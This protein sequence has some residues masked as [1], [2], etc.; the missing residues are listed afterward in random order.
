M[1]AHRV[2]IGVAALAV[3]SAGAAR[4]DLRLHRVDLIEH[5]R[6]C[7]FGFNV[8][9]SVR[10]LVSALD[11]EGRVIDLRGEDFTLILDS[12]E[13]Q[14][15]FRLTRF[16]S[17][18]PPEEM[19]VVVVIQTSPSM[20]GALDEAARGVGA[21]ADSL[22]AKPTWKMALLDY[23]RDVRTRAQLSAAAT[24]K[25]VL[26]R[27][28]VDRE[29]GEVHLLDAVRTAIDQLKAEPQRK[30]IVVISDGENLSLDRGAFVKLGKLA[31]EHGVNVDTVGWARD[32][33]RLRNL[34]EL[35]RGS[36][37]TH[38]QAA[39]P[40]GIAAQLAAVSGEIKQAIVLESS[41][42][43]THQDRD[44]VVQ[45]VAKG[46]ERGMYSNTLT[47]RQRKIVD[48]CPR[49]PWWDRPLW[50]FA[51]GLVLLLAAA[52]TVVL[53]SRRRRS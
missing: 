8:D 16:E 1:G 51:A 46:A 44:V 22:A 29:A 24:I 7:R 5:W 50:P 49:P 9:R 12:A 21:L 25:P 32:P 26:A 45:L 38:R 33:A 14:A 3:L 10:L 36:D 13:Q 27:L 41:D 6:C 42:F 30:L 18:E 40:A 17:A 34:S 52:A 19:A 31:R 48:D 20:A 35:A 15:S 28:E 37:G 4:A 43:T 11:Q 47:T 39:T 53:V 23:S 2:A